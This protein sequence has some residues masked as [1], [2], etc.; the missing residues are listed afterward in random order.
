MHKSRQLPVYHVL[1]FF[2]DDHDACALTVLV[3]GVRFHINVDPS[4]FN[5]RSMANKKI[6]QEYEQLLRKIKQIEQEDDDDD[7]TTDLQQD[8]D[9]VAPQSDETQDSGIGITYSEDEADDDK[10]CRK[11]TNDP[12]EVL[13]QWILSPFVEIFSNKKFKPALSHT[14]TVQ[15]WYHCLTYF[16]HLDIAE[17]QLHAK[18]ESYSDSLEEQ[19]QNLIPTLS[20]PKYIRD[21]KIPVIN[22]A[23]ITVVTESDEPAPI[24]PAIVELDDG[25]GYFLKT[26][27]M[28]QIQP[29]KRE[30]QI[31]KKLEKKGLREEFRFPIIRNLVRFEDDSQTQIMGFP[32]DVIP[33]A[34]P[35]TKLFD[36]KISQKQREKWAKESKRIVQLLHDH[37]LVWGDAKA[38]NFMVDADDN[39]WIIDFGGSYTD[40]WIDPELKE[41]EEGDDMGVRKI[42]NALR[43]PEENT[44]VPGEEEK[45]EQVSKESV[46][47]SPH[48]KRK[49][50]SNPEEEDGDGHDKALKQRKVS[51]TDRR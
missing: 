40:G 23:D 17:G 18:E 7:E 11:N 10:S 26:V 28:Q 2:R 35:L 8:E 25:S 24:H 1:D 29:M 34:T 30:I 20:L 21:L 31:L 47:K 43:D 39:L 9:D 48:S 14:T 50:R 44:F 3:N 33:D 22:A 41:T 32:M 13:H 19:I 4:R 51:H 16:F 37:G 36:S 49:R 38:D 27:D 42:G 46:Q 15:Q 6:A 5:H 45:Q 12:V